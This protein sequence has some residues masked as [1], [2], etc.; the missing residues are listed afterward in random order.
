MTAIA[1]HA[2]V[3]L[4]PDNA[5]MLAV[6]VTTALLWTRWRRLGR[7]L[8]TL[9]AAMLVACGTL[10]IG[11]WMSEPLDGCFATPLSL[12]QAVD[13]I[14]VLGGS[15]R[16]GPVPERPDSLINVSGR[17]IAF[18]E[19]AQRYPA[20]RLVFTGGA[21]PHVA[22]ATTEVDEARPIL[23]ALGIPPSR[24]LFEAKA[25]NTIENARR[26][27]AL[28]APR[29]GERW[30]LIT[31]A[32]HMP[33]AVAVFEREDWPVVP[34]PV[35]RPDWARAAPIGLATGLRALGNA[36]HE[37]LGLLY[38]RVTDATRTVVPECRSAQS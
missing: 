18:A 7:L 17:L 20:A 15:I 5:F 35:D 32:L 14:I 21:P 33:R 2:G 24:V 38:Y 31:T 37:W 16:I 6:G 1:K 29:P 4:Q 36:T 13:G 22:N 11:R 25:H 3:L 34:Y 8:A 19:L 26:S 23:Q 30:I 10:P 27:K 9:G 28:A 12:P